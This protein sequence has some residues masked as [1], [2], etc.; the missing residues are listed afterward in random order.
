MA[1]AGIVSPSRCVRLPEEPL[2][3]IKRRQQETE[4]QTETEHQTQKETEI[5]RRKT[6]SA[7]LQGMEIAAVRCGFNNSAVI[8]N[9]K[10]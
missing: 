1:A 2:S 3:S 4:T 8:I 9:P 5:E 7:L 6:A 10:P